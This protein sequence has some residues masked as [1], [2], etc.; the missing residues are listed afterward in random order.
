MKTKLEFSTSI[1][2]PREKVWH[3]LWDD[4]TYRRWSSAFQDG[5][6]AVSDWNEGSKIQFLT[7]EGDGMFSVIERSN[8]PEFMSFKHLGTIKEGEEQLL[9]KESQRWEGAHENYLLKEHDDHTILSVS[10]DTISNYREY[11]QKTFPKALEL[12]KSLSES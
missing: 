12:I 8:A 9:D 10:M 6:Y 4:S 7:P 3:I 11:F 1:N 5:S 2:A